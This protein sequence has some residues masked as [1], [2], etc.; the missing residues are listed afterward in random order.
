M[1]LQFFPLPGT[2]CKSRIGYLLIY[3]SLFFLHAEWWLRKECNCSINRLV[4]L[5]TR[6][7][8]IVWFWWQ[9]CCTTSVPWTACVFYVSTSLTSVHE[10]H[11][12]KKH[13]A[14]VGQQQPWM[15]L[16]HQLALVLCNKISTVEYYTEYMKLCLCKIMS[17]MGPGHEHLI[18][19]LVHTN[20]R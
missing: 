13:D 18:C 6:V 3:I 8:M 9:L 10:L 16:L 7:A 2:Y 4:V 11:C 14:F 15:Y 5:G 1:I 19:V 17:E 12:Q 20:W